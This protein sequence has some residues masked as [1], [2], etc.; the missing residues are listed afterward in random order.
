[1]E[2]L[3]K[4]LEKQPDDVFLLYAMAMEHKKSGR[5]SEALQTLQRVTQLDPNYSYAYF[6]QGLIFEQQGDPESAKRVYREGI[7]SANRKG[8]AHARSELEGQLSMIE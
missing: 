1:M 6:Q 4:M 3:L 5:L 7:D 8:D 2:Q